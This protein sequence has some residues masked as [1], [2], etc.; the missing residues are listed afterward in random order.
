[1]ASG[2]SLY[3]SLVPRLERE[4]G[5]EATFIPGQ[6]KKGTGLALVPRALCSISFSVGGHKSSDK[7]I[8][9]TF[10]T[11]FTQSVGTVRA[12]H[13]TSSVSGVKMQLLTAKH[14]SVCLAQSK[15]CPPP[16]SKD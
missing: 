5:N 10:I 1:M 3:S 11:I 14:G 7:T 12:V 6:E 13:W 9:G 16:T 4:P 8:A 2:Y 15:R